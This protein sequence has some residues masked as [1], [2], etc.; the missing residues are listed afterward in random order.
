MDDA[1]YQK[2]LSGVGLGAKV[3]WDRMPAGVDPL[4]HKNILGFTT[5]LLTDTG[6]L[7]TGRF[8]V[9]SGHRRKPEFSPGNPINM[10]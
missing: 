8:T 3:L 9:V 6:S 5:G 2:F 1:L 7:F 10:N 4:G